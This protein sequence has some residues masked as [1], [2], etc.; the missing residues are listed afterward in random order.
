MNRASSVAGRQTESAAKQ[1]AQPLWA[2]TSY[3]NPM[4]YQRRLANYRSFREHLAV[5]LLTVELSYDAEFELQAD[6]ADVL[7]QLRGRDVMWQ[8]ERLLNVALG[9]LPKECS[10][11]VWLDCDVVIFGGEEWAEGVSGLLDDFTLVQ[12]HNRVHYL[13]RDLGP[14]ESRSEA[15]LLDEPSRSS[16]ASAVASGL[17]AHT[18][19]RQTS[20]MRREDTYAPGIAWA[21][22]R[23]LLDEHG[24]YDTLI[25]GGGDYAI[26]CATYGV[27]DLA[28]EFHSM[29]SRQR[30]HYLAWAK[31]YFES[32]GGAVS[33]ADY[34]LYHLARRGAQPAAPRAVRRVGAFPVRP[35]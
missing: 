13:P 27:F 10:K 9:A 34:E 25:V 31:P 35:V 6:E 22:R 5:P 20:D 4:R 29:N 7:V 23:E 14:G 15:G 30:E 3:F 11:V 16:V 1:R 17:S 26:T 21:A 2:I 24:F 19:V 12:P 32:V 18:S 8:K 28:I 33:F